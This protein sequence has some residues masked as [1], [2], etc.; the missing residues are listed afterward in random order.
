MRFFSKYDA[1][2]ITIICALLCIFVGLGVLFLFVDPWY[3][4]IIYFV[5]AV[6]V[7]INFF[8]VRMYLKEDRLTIWFGI[9]P[10]NI[11]YSDIRE[12]SR[13]YNVLSSFATSRERIAIRKSD[14]QYFSCIYISPKNDE[15]FLQ[16]LIKHCPNAKV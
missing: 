6:F 9:I 10:K 2:Y 5:L 15:L 8:T 12:I 14:S 7:A 11:K 16:E 3:F 13:S 4:S 1:F